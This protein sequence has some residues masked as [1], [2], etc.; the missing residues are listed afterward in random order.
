MKHFISITCCLLALCLAGPA[1][2]TILT[3]DVDR[4]PGTAGI[5]D[6][7]DNCWG[8]DTDLATYGDNVSASPQTGPALVG[9]PTY[10]NVSTEYNYSLGVEGTTPGLLVSYSDDGNP[11]NRIRYRTS[12]NYGDLQRF[13]NLSV[14]GQSEISMVT[15]QDDP[16]DATVFA[17]ALLGF[18]LAAGNASG[19]SRTLD[20]LEVRDGASVIYSQDDVVI[21]G[22][23]HTS[24]NFTSSPLIGSSGALSIVLMFDGGEDLNAFGLDNVQFA[25]FVPEPGTG[26][27]FLLGGALGWRRRRGVKRSDDR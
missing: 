6:L 3:F 10:G 2:A 14:A 16:S 23:T 21:D 15:I 11:N 7:S 9:D 22:T 20:R 27:L 13:I 1:G 25:Q 24:F 12:S 8:I 17:P 26:A 5:Q 19:G 4:D 18:D